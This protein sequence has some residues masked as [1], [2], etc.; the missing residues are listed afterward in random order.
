VTSTNCR[1][2]TVV[3]PN[4]VHTVVRNMWRKETDILRK[5]VHRVGF[6]Y[7]IVQGYTVNK[8]WN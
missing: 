7:K 6:I 8:T 2:N 5:I 1:I 3:S 4:D